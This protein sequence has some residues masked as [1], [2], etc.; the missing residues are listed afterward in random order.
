MPM[1]RHDK[2]GGVAGR[3]VIIC[4]LGRT[5]NTTLSPVELTSAPIVHITVHHVFPN[6]EL[7]AG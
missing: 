7:R 6:D 1:L 5:T 3:H 4:L 2:R